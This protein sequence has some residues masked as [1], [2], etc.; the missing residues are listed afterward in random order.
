[1]AVEAWLGMGLPHRIHLFGILRSPNTMTVIPSHKAKLLIPAIVRLR[2]GVV[3]FSVPVCLTGFGSCSLVTHVIWRWLEV[4]VDGGLLRPRCRL[5]LSRTWSSA[6]VSLL[7]SQ[8]LRC[9]DGMVL[10]ISFYGMHR[11]V[12]LEVEY[13]SVLRIPQ[14]YS[15]YHFAL[16]VRGLLSDWFFN[17]NLLLLIVFMFNLFPLRRREAQLESLHGLIRIHILILLS[18]IILLMIHLIQHSDSLFMLKLLDLVED[19]F[20][21]CFESLGDH[22]L[23]DY[24]ACRELTADHRHLWLIHLEDFGQLFGN[25]EELFVYVDEQCLDI[26]PQLWP[27]LLINY[28]WYVA[29]VRH[30]LLQISELLLAPL[31]LQLDLIELL[32]GL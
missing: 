6:V 30:F 13:V 8:V 19:L 21:L 1:M 25:R 15:C 17:L 28:T 10:A 23:V 32:N 16:L 24:S 11:F 31:I 3:S 26:D 5:M 7:F 9:F 12:D 18:E 4:S 2:S 27:I 20:L 22:L 14:I 29:W